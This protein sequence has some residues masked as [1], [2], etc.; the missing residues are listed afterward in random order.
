[1]HIH[2][3]PAQYKTFFVTVPALLNVSH[4]AKDEYKGV[5]TA[6]IGVTGDTLSSKLVLSYAAPFN[7][8]T[9]CIRLFSF[10]ILL[11]KKVRKHF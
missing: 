9:L 7:S 1:M 6:R 4:N 3:V 5:L 11:A 2:Y 8:G 10:L